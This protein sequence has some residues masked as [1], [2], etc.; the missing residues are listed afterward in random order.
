VS[1]AFDEGA[2][3]DAF[4]ESHPRC[5]TCEERLCT[6]GGP[7]AD[8]CVGGCHWDHEPIAFEHGG[9]R[10]CQP[11]ADDA[12]ALLAED[13]SAE[14][15]RALNYPWPCPTCGCEPETDITSSY[16]CVSCG[17]CFD[18]DLVG[19]PPRYV[20]CAPI[21]AGLTVAEAIAS[22]N[23]AVEERAARS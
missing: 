23:E 1:Y 7:T 19:D 6:A 11:C 20:P 22:W 12:R 5:E 9:L 2:Y 4:R 15:R 18:A 14:L 8:L 10:Y 21:G 17:S 16:P 3:E 13:I